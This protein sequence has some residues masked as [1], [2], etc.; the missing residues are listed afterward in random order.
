M[1]YGTA[2]HLATEAEVRAAF[3]GDRRVQV[4]S[5]GQEKRF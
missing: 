5:P 2:P 3:A 4:L 1:H